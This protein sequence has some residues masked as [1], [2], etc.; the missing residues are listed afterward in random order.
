MN[1]LLNPFGGQT[2][3]AIV[4]QGQEAVEKGLAMNAKTE[5]ERDY[6]VAISAFLAATARPSAARAA[7]YE[8]AMEARRQVPGGGASMIFS[9][10]R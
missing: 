1:R 8:A 5:R 2:A 3:E 9:R 6:L 4:L 7:R 10:S